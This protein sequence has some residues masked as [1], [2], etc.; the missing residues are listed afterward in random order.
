MTRTSRR[1]ISTGCKGLRNSRVIEPSSVRVKILVGSQLGS[2]ALPVNAVVTGTPASGFEVA[3]ITVKPVV[4][5][6]EG[7]AGVLSSLLKVDTGPVSVSGAAADV[8]QTVPLSLA[9]G[10]SALGSSDVQVT[11]HLRFELGRIRE[12]VIQHLPRL[13]ERRA[14]VEHLLKL[15]AGIGHRRRI[16]V[17]EEDEDLRDLRFPSPLLL[18][19]R[20]RGRVFGFSELAGRGLGLR[21]RLWPANSEIVSPG[22][23]A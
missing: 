12:P 7:E 15:R 5:S 9:T 20:A 2:K 16:N 21:I 22:T 23:W 3:T 4:V 10:L 17:L 1:S 11:V 14:E 6:I 18:P 13:F 8:N 19:T